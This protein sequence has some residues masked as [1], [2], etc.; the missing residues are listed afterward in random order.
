MV[1][2]IAV[3]AVRSRP[4]ISANVVFRVQPDVL[5]EVVE[6][7]SGAWLRVRHEDGVVG[8]I[9]AMEVWGH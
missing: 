9:S 7:P 4:E 5:L 2:S 3:A 6:S 8:Y 1:V